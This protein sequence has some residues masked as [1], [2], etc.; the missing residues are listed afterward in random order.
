MSKL[1]L[2]LLIVVVLVLFFLMFWIVALSAALLLF[3]RKTVLEKVPLERKG[4]DWV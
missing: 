3:G 4:K 1:I 2:G